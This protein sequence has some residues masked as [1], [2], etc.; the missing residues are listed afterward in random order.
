M[1]SNKPMGR[2]DGEA[3]YIFYAGKAGNAPDLPAQKSQI[4]VAQR[5]RINN[6][7]S[8]KLTISFLS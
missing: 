4:F 8:R 6:E 1:L 7:E 3:V 2:G 5:N